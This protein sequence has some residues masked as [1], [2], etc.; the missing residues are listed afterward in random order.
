MERELPRRK[1]ALRQLGSGLKV[2][3]G[4]SPPLSVRLP[5]VAV[6]SCSDELNAMPERTRPEKTKPTPPGEDVVE[7]IDPGHTDEDFLDD[8]E[9]ATSDEAR[10]KLGL[11]SV[12]ER[13]SSRT[14]E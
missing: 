1:P 9:K 10:K 7:K 11:P 6:K 2:G 4:S 14:S 3:C 5:M 12:P 8:L 13:G